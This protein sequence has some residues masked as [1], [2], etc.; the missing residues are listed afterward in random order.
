MEKM[1]NKSRNG[2]RE[3]PFQTQTNDC[4]KLKNYFIFDMH[5]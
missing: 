3:F 2:N 4:F 1:W 5:R